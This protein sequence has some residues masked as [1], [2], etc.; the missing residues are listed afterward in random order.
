MGMRYFVFTIA[1]LLAVPAMAAPDFGPTQY[2]GPGAQIESKGMGSPSPLSQR[3]TYGSSGYDDENVDARMQQRQERI[4]KE[5]ERKR[6]RA[7]EV[8]EEQRL[9]DYL[10]NLN[11]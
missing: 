5:V 7:R 2:S 1:V 10:L 4:Y 8:N 3:Q 11:E 9:K 6:E